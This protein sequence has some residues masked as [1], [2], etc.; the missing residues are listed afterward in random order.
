[1]ASLYTIDASV[2]VAACRPQESGH[3]ASQAFLAAV[4]E[5]AFPLIEPSI[6]P[7]EV[8]SALVRT[9]SNRV[10]AGEYATV[11]LNLPMLTLVAMDERFARQ[12]VDLT[13]ATRLRAADAVYATVAAHFGARLVTLDKEQIIRAPKSVMVCRPADAI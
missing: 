7:I 13:V 11:I 10:L 1:M 3:V 8:A 4:R 6:L 5:H 12:A 2:F 9:G